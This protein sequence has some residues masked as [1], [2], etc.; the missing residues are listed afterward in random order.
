MVH[1]SGD[2]S[3]FLHC[4]LAVARAPVGMTRGEVGSSI[5]ALKRCATQNL[6]ERRG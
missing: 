2:D 5:A 6:I 4:A 1:R 3:R